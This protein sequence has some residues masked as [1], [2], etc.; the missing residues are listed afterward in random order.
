MRSAAEP[1]RGYPR[2]SLGLL[3][4]LA[5]L[6]MWEAFLITNRPQTRGC[7]GNFSQYYAAGTIVR[8][9]EY[10]RLYDQA[11]FQHLQE[12]LRDD[13]LPSIYPPTVGVLVAPLTQLS[14]ANAL[15]VWW[16]IQS[17]CI[18]ATGVLFYRNLELPRPWRVNALA[19]LAA[20]LPLWIA[21]GIGQLAPLFVLVLAGGLELHKRG[22]RAS[23]GLLLSL[24]ALKPQL[25][26]GL[27]LWMF[28]RRDYRTLLGLAAGFGVQAAAVAIAVGPEAWLDYFHALPSI[29]AMTRRTHFSPMVE[30]SFVG[31]A[32]NLA[33][34][35][36][37]AAWETMAM[38]LAYA[39]SV[40]VALVMLCRVVW[41]RQAEIRGQRS[42]VEGLTS[43]L[44]PPTSANCEYAC[45]VLFMTIV[46][47]YLIVYDQSLIAVALVMLWSSP[48]WRWGI[49]LWAAMTAVAGNISLA[50]GFNVTALAALAAMYALSRSPSPFP[51]TADRLSGPRE[52][53]LTS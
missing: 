12:P 48:R 9:G 16:A 33:L 44:R 36:G 18:V 27:V 10:R 21:I 41:T 25:A 37:R 23:A 35:A 14:Y 49:V 22:Q 15:A 11:Y 31:I 7:G 17:L 29:S 51:A 1:L 13:P 8:S 53:F 45:G 6:A 19:A 26:A 52:R 43:D 24:L 38:K 28:L 20:L 32:S 34:A 40:S 30:A 3:T 2:L 42:E 4:A 47:P 39:L 5:L 46:P 50:L